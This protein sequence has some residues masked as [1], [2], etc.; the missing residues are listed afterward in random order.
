MAEKSDANTKFF[1][2]MANIRR[3]KNFIHALQSEEGLATSQA[4]KQEIVYHHFL[5]HTGTYLPR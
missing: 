5:K 4:S 1:H 2:I 3:K